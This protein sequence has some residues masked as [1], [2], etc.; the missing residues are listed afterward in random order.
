M[1]R[2]LQDLVHKCHGDHRPECPI[3]DDLAGAVVADRTVE[4]RTR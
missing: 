2:T 1:R 4:G 3:L